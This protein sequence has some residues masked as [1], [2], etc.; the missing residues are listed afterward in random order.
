MGIL[1]INVHIYI[2]HTHTHTQVFKISSLTEL[3]LELIN[4]TRQAGQQAP[5]ILLSLS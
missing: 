1:P 4:L 5:G 2:I 3:N